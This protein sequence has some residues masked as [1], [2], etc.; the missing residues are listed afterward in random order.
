MAVVVKEVIGLTV[1]MLKI[2]ECHCIAKQVSFGVTCIET[3]YFGSRS[4]T[5]P[6]IH[7]KQMHPAFLN[8]LHFL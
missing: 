3:G 5:D 4:G 6:C 8:S 7:S 1:S 2:E